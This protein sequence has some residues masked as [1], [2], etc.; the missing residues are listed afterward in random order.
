MKSYNRIYNLLIEAEGVPAHWES[1]TIG[2]RIR[3]L[4]RAVRRKPKRTKITAR[5]LPKTYQGKLDPL[6]QAEI[7]AGARA[8]QRRF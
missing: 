3:R 1:P 6:A 5:E 2:S 4:L 8:A 7:D